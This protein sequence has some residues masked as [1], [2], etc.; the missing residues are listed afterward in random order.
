MVYKIRACV[1]C[2]FYKVNYGCGRMQN[3][4]PKVWPSR[5]HC[6]NKVDVLERKDEGTVHITSVKKAEA[7]EE[8]S[9]LF[10][11]DQR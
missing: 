6:I 7:W 10:S 5:K 3:M 1:F 4:C 11:H 2:F 9:W 8:Y